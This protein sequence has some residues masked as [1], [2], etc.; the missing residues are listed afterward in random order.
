MV[1][2]EAFE[3]FISSEMEEFAYE[4]A[5]ALVFRNITYHF[6]VGKKD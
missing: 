2:R 4:F 1:V 5:N 3:D 6:S